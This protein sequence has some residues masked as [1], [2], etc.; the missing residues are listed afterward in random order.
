MARKN[1]IPEDDGEDAVIDKKSKRRLAKSREQQQR[2]QNQ[3]EPA[4]HDDTMSRVA[5][6]CQEQRWREA[7]ALCL[8]AIAKAREEGRADAVAGLSMAAHKVECSLRRQM[9][10]A[11]IVKAQEMLKKEYL[12]DVC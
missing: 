6:F 5:L 1:H 3:P 12:L 10:A 2:T 9:A 7:L 4:P 11:F 8:K